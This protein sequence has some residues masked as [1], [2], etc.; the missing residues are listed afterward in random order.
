MP[1]PGVDRL[2]KPKNQSFSFY[3]SRLSR[4]SDLFSAL[5]RKQ[6]METFLCFT[7]TQINVTGA[8]TTNFDSVSS[9]MCKLTSILFLFF[10]H[11][12]A[13]KPNCEQRNKSL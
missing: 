3:N 10:F 13:T 6:Y 12:W 8:E 11:L 4:S 1:T 7:E 9:T 5:Q 2:F